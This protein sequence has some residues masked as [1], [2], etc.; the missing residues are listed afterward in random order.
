LTQGQQAAQ[1]GD[2]RNISRVLVFKLGGEVH[3]PPVP[4]PWQHTPSPPPDTADAATLKTGFELFAQFCLPCHGT[5]A[6]GGGVV[7]D[8]RKSPFLPVDFLQHRSRRHPEE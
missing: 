5:A 2:T 6:V 4:P 3:L 7:P 8:L 1:S